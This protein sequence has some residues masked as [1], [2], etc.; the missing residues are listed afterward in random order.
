MA[1]SLRTYEVYS[2]AEAVLAV[3]V[4]PPHG[5]IEV[6]ETTPTIGNSR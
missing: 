3:C 6:F 1:A 2:A 5:Y 4:D